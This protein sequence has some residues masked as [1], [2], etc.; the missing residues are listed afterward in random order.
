[1]PLIRVRY[2][3]EE[4]FVAHILRNYIKLE[5]FKLCKQCLITVNDT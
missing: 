3:F 1:M 2:A 5:F 4:A